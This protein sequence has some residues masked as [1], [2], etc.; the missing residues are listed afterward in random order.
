MAM[1]PSAACQRPSLPAKL[2]SLAPMTSASRL[3]SSPP[4]HLSR[5]VISASS[6]QKMNSP[7]LR[8]RLK[9]RRMPMGSSAS[10]QCVTKLRAHEVSMADLLDIA[11]STA[12]DIVKIDGQRV[13]VHGVSVDAI[14]S[15]VARFPE[16]K[17]LING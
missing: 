9:C 3:I 7:Y 1:S 5:P 8:S 2:R 13:K 4:Y 6:L 16:L 15:F 17:S 10:G 14:A 11:P 12:V